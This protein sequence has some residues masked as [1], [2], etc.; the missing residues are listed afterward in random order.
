MD[1]TQYEN[2]DIYQVDYIVNIEADQTFTEIPE[3]VSLKFKDHSYSIN[4]SKLKANQLKVEIKSTPS[5]KRI[6]ASD[7]PEFKTYV[8]NVLDAQDTFIGYK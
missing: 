4:Y 7:Y 6:E 2:M 8:K 3:N 5:M 1:Y